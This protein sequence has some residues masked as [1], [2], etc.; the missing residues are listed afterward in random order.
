LLNLTADGNS[1]LLEVKI[2]PGASRTRFLGEWSGRARIAVAAPPEKGRANQVL[3]EFLG[4]FL[5]IGGRRVQLV[6]GLSSPLKTARIQ[7]VS[8]DAVRTAF[9]ET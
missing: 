5:G 1:V 2:V 6:S 8:I 4:E 3:I 9:A 7:G